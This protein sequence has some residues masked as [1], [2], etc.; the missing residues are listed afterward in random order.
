MKDGT[1]KGS[2]LPLPGEPFPSRTVRKAAKLLY[3]RGGFRELSVFLET[4]VLDSS[5]FPG[6]SPGKQGS[7]LCTRISPP[8]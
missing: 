1:L 6:Q 2:S 8:E 5:S 7:T 4:K 3:H